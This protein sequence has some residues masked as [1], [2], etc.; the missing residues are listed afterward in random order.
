MEEVSSGGQHIEGGRERR[1][2][3]A[4]LLSVGGQP[5]RIG[6]PLSLSGPHPAPWPAGPDHCLKALYF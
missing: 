6:I 5:P 2:P 1:A 4:R 3:L